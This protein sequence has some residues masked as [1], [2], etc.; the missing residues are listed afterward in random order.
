MLSEQQ[1][2]GTETSFKD[3]LKSAELTVG[4]L[5]NDTGCIIVRIERVHEDERNVDLMFRI[6]V[7]IRTKSQNQLLCLLGFSASCKRFRAHL[8]LSNTEI[9]ESHSLSNFNDGFGSD[10][11]HGGA[12]TSVE[13][14]DS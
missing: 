11:T 14:Q 1:R 12:K 4:I 7:L 6:E 10:A 3:S 2:V 9:Q 8:D 5:L 13:L